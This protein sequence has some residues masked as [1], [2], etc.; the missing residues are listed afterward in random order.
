MATTGG[1]VDFHPAARA[2][3]RI[4]GFPDARHLCRI[5]AAVG[6]AQNFA[7]LRALA[8]EGIQK[9]HMSRHARAVATAAGAAPEQVE[10]LAEALIAAGEIKVERARQI[11]AGGL[12]G[13]GP[14]PSRSSS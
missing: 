9:G 5:A 10:E 7:A 1:S 4:L 13:A 8:T 14:A 6:L 3:L 12:G 2:S 11:L